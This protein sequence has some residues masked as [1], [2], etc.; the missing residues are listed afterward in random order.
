MI[1]ADADVPAGGAFGEL[2]RPAFLL[3]LQ[4]RQPLAVGQGRPE[5]GDFSKVSL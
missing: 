4:P 3:R 5:H 2:N 1:K